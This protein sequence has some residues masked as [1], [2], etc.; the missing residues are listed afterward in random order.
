M[1][2]RFPLDELANDLSH[3]ALPNAQREQQLLRAHVGVVVQG[4]TPMS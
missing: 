1:P 3:G 4:K 2:Y